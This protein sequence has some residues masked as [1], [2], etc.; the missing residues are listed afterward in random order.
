V[1]PY[2]CASLPIADLIPASSFPWGKDGMVFFQRMQEL[3][4]CVLRGS[5]P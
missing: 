3:A 2:R 5:S 4:F 1:N